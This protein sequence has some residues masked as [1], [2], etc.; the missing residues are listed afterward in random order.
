M[1]SV[2]D[3]NRDRREA[4]RVVF[5]DPVEIIGD[6][7]VISAHALDVSAGGI[8]I[9]AE[10]LEEGARVRVRFSLGDSTRRVD[11]VA[12]VVRRG[13]GSTGLRFENM[14][15]VARANLSDYV[16]AVRSGAGYPR[17]VWH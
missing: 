2:L 9:D 15:W 8:S 13:P 4:P 1:M 6:E 11:T 14:P 12:R 7:T 17:S 5:C 16:T 3:T 10:S